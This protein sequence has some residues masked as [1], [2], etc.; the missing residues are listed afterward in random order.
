MLSLQMNGQQQVGW[1]E[2]PMPEP[3]AGEVVIRTAMSALCGSELGR[4]R[5]DGMAQGNT[6]HEA[7][8]TVVAVGEGVAEP[9]VGQRVGVSAIAGCGH[10]DY[11][12]NK[13]YTWCPK[14]KF[15]GSMHAEYFTASALACHVLPDDL[16]WEIGVLLTGDG[17]GVPYHT[18]TKFRS[19]DVRNVAIFGAGPI[20]LGSVIMQTYLKRRV[21]IVDF[22][23]ERLAIA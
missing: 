13:Q 14:R 16:S 21:I 10:C 20:G 1:I 9:K 4:Y 2:Q 11:C 6:G 17:F 7:A 12:A 3:K 23:A 5:G 22:S 18:S 15:Y 8:G 19:G